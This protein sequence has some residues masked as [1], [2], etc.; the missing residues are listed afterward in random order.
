MTV[1]E[2]AALDLSDDEY[3][4]VQSVIRN[5]YRAYD[6]GGDLVL[7]GK[8]QLFKLR[9]EFPFVDAD[10]DPAFTVKASGVLDVA[11]DYALIDDRTGDA[12]V[13][14]DRNVA[15]VHDRWTLRDPDTGAAVAEIASKSRLVSLLRHVHA[16]FSLLPH[17]YEITGPD[18]R[19]VGTIDGK[20][21]VRDRYVV[22]IDDADAVPREA[23]LAAAMV[24]DAIE[25]N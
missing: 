13:V 17:E 7:R 20:L 24:V 10:G 19:R 11:A 21:S 14:L 25:E 12:V 18:G 16:L 22:R 2:I 5:K 1:D 9:E 15:L 8:Q 23:V 6:A 3:E 4:V